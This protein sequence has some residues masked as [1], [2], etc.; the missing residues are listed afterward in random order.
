[1]ICSAPRVA[2]GFPGVRGIC[3]TFGDRASKPEVSKDGYS[4][5]R[6]DDFLQLREVRRY[7]DG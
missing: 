1:M 7:D 6:L 4:F 5:Y 3:M 2:F